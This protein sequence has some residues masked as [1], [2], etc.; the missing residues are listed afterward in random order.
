MIIKNSDV[1]YYKY[2][3]LYI[4]QLE[5]QELC[6]QITLQPSFFLGFKAFL[7]AVIKPEL[8]YYPNNFRKRKV[9]Q[10]NIIIQ[11]YIKLINSQERIALS[12]YQEIIRKIFIYYQ[13]GFTFSCFN[14]SFFYWIA[15]IP[16]LLRIFTHLD[17]EGI[18]TLKVENVHTCIK[19]IRKEGRSSY[20]PRY[21]VILDLCPI[22]VITHFLRLRKKL[23]K[24]SDFIF[25]G[26]VSGI[27]LTSESL[28]KIVSIQLGNMG[29]SEEDLNSIRGT[30]N[31]STN[32]TSTP[33]PFDKTSNILF[34]KYCIKNKSLEDAFELRKQEIITELVQD[35]YNA[36]SD[37][38]LDLMTN[39]FVSVELLNWQQRN[40]LNSS[41]KEVF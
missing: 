4:L 38:E 23:W 24:T 39:C 6:W 19:E 14:Q 1:L 10:A 20:I 3:F 30:Y 2:L 22:E 18:R 33:K 29:L 9:I 36:S 34:W 7:Y 12:K 31:L 21:Q 8:D 17:W 35:L 15:K 13:S 32:I 27:V 37:K 40:M 25:A 41:S 16:I 28:F 5:K 11:N 26:S